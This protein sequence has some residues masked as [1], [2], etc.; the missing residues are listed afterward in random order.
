M[1]TRGR[2]QLWQRRHQHPGEQVD[3]WHSA[4]LTIASVVVAACSLIQLK[5]Q[6]A[7]C[8]DDRPRRGVGRRCSCGSSS[9]HLP[10]PPNAT[11]DDS[12][13]SCDSKHG[14]F[15]PW[16]A[17][18]APIPDAGELACDRDLFMCQLTACVCGCSRVLCPKT[19]L[20]DGLCHAVVT[21]EKRPCVDVAR[22]APIMC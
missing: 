15:S 8:F 16:Q 5:F 7:W 20:K 12:E 18:G 11:I 6:Q 9:A 17:T 1:S 22:S 10:E 4:T 13:W 3:H 2:H 19:R 21:A 14:M